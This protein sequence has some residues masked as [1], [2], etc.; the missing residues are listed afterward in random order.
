MN[1]IKTIKDLFIPSTLLYAWF[2]VLWNVNYNYT[3]M[4]Q[5][6]KISSDSSVDRK[7]VGSDNEQIYNPQKH[8]LEM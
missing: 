4:I 8:L 6:Q 1:Y 3:I 2:T 7:P 5:K